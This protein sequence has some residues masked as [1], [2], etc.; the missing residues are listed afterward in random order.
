MSTKLRD[1][2]RWQTAASW[3]ALCAAACRPSAGPADV[4]T[5]DSGLRDVAADR[6]EAATD[7]AVA[8]TRPQTDGSARFEYVG[9][10][11]LRLFFR[12]GHVVP[13]AGTCLD[14][15]NTGIFLAGD[16]QPNS[17]RIGD[18]YYS[19]M[20]GSAARVNTRTGVIE[21]LTG[22]SPDRRELGGIVGCTRNRV[23]LAFT[24]YDESGSEFLA[25]RAGVA[26]FDDVTGVGRIVWSIDY[27][28]RMPRVS[29][30][31]MKH[32]VATEDVLAWIVIPELGPYQ[33]WVSGP[34]GENP[35]QLPPILPEPGVGVPADYVHA[36]GPNL[37]LGVFDILYHWRLGDAAYR[38]ISPAPVRA[39]RPWIHGNYVTWVGADAT[40][41][42]AG[43][44]PERNNNIYLHDLRSGQTRVISEDPP[45]RPT[46]QNY[47]T[48]FGDWVTYA[49][50]RNAM[51][52][53]PAAN[54]TDR[55]EL[56]G[57]H[58]PTGRTVPVLTGEVTVGL[59]RFFDD[60]RVTVECR[61]VGHWDGGL[62]RVV[63]VPVPSVPDE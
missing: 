43:T 53:A 9:D 55:M 27:P 25:P 56:F 29:G 54:F 7:A 62:F 23:A 51:N 44:P 61:D 19:S 3:L 4:H 12:Q 11:G 15:P 37:V 48:V 35:R 13:D 17:C 52:P 63:S 14:H 5:I 20:H 31:G 21:G 46:G 8:D 41:T 49:D 50:F 60:G 22:S 39:Q 10:A 40:P 33:L 16:H 28:R 2:L 6:R 24:E 45:G 26:I 59:S 38:R 42:D 30:W 57:Y 1:G 18:W 32:F 36:D 58:I 34:N 47:P